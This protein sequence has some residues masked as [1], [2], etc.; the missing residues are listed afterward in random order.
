MLDIVKTRASTWQ[1]HKLKSYAENSMSPDAPDLPLTE[2][3]AVSHPFYR[4]GSLDPVA[5]R[6]HPSE[7]HAKT[8]REEALKPVLPIIPGAPSR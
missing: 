4:P 8:V 7:V 6:E 3:L 1:W 2:V 5:Y